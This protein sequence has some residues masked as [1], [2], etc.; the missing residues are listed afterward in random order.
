[1]RIE[2]AILLV[3]LIAG[4]TQGEQI[5]EHSDDIVTID[6]ILLL[7]R[8]PIYTGSFPGRHFGCG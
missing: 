8:P 5:K 7:P 4:C 2:I 1:M 3:V 6:N